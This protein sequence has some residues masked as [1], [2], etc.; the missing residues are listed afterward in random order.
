[1]DALQSVARESDFALV[2]AQPA[3]YRRV[4]E[5]V[6]GKADFDFERLQTYCDLLLCVIIALLLVW[7][8][9]EA[10]LLLLLLLLLRLRGEA[11]TAR[12]NER[13]N[14]RRGVSVPVRSA[15]FPRLLIA[16]WYIYCAR[17]VRHNTGTCAA[18]W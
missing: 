16:E 17:T 5:D 13:T 12:P 8:F 11:L 1:M 9:D 14:E 4:F 18:V 7:W 10:L 3:D 2:K 6:R 15:Q